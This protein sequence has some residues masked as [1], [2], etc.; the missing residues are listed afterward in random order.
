[1]RLHGQVSVGFAKTFKGMRGAVMIDRDGNKAWHPLIVYYSYGCMHLSSLHQQFRPIPRCMKI[2]APMSAI[3]C[4]LKRSGLSGS[5]KNRQFW[6]QRDVSGS[7]LCNSLLV[8]H[9]WVL[10]YIWLKNVISIVQHDLSHRVK[11]GPTVW[12]GPKSIGLKFYFSACGS[13]TA[14]GQKQWLTHLH[15]SPAVYPPPHLR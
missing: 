5:F 6:W 12:E 15:L 2:D 3:T 14:R 1:M 11:T 13:S 4:K 10:S 9:V 7:L 8:D